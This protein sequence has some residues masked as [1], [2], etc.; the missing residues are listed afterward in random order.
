MH[1]PDRG[2]C[3]GSCRARAS[4]P[5]LFVNGVLRGQ[6][7]VERGIFAPGACDVV[8]IAL[9][10]ALACNASTPGQG[11]NGYVVQAFALLTSS[12]AKSFVQSN[13]H[14]A[15]GVLHANIVGVQAINASNRFEGS[16]VTYD[17]SFIGLALERSRSVQLRYS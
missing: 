14:V 8:E 11:F 12:P 3:S 7:A 2:R 5:H 9:P 16:G 17:C 13:R 10:A 6:S 15:D 4:L 1:C